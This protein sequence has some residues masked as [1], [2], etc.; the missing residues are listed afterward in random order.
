M[1]RLGL[2]SIT[3]VKLFFDKKS[4]WG[5]AKNRPSVASM[6]VY[7]RR[8]TTGS[9]Q[10]ADGSWTRLGSWQLAIGSWQLATTT[11]TGNG[12]NLTAKTWRW[13]AGGSDSFCG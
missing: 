5:G 4:F 3:Y 11:A 13:V 8:R 6:Y 7:G 12:E 2:A 1:E 9:W 10:L